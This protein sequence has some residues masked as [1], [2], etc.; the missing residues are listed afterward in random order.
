M[1]ST[2]ANLSRHSLLTHT[3]DETSFQTVLNAVVDNIPSISLDELAVIV[4]I[5]T[6]LVGFEANRLQSVLAEWKEFVA[7]GVDRVLQQNNA[8]SLLPLPEEVKREMNLNYEFT[9][10]CCWISP[11]KSMRIVLLGNALFSCSFF[12]K[13]DNRSGLGLLILQAL[14]IFI[15]VMGLNLKKDAKKSAE[16]YRK[17]QPFSCFDDFEKKLKDYVEAWKHN[18]NKTIPKQFRAEYTRLIE[19][20][21]ELDNS[22]PKWCWLQLVRHSHQLLEENKWVAFGEE[23]DAELSR[24]RKVSSES[25]NYDEYSRLAFVWSSYLLQGIYATEPPRKEDLEKVKKLSEKSVFAKL[26]VLVHEQS[27]KRGN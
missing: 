11:S 23:G 26:A 13:P 27:V 3:S 8:D 9:T 12:L 22:L 5:S 1:V 7:R 4:A 17:K 21:K 10:G 6:F 14:H 25:M 19:S 18:E 16:E 24:I 20:E 15:C 2:S